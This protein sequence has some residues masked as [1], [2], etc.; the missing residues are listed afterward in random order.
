MNPISPS[1]NLFK[2]LHCLPASLVL[3]LL[4]ATAKAE[5]KPLPKP[6]KAHPHVIEPCFKFRG[7]LN[8][9]NGAPTYR[10]MHFG[11]K[12]ILGVSDSMALPDYWKIPES[13]AAHLKTFD[14]AVIADFE[15]CP[16]T[17]DRPGVM[18]LGCIESATNFKVYLREN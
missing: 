4:I 7:R 14:S 2:R 17:K 1:N 11:T 13:V 3:L 15:F 5:N 6:C 10:I 12:R 8:A 9:W 16:F 18:R